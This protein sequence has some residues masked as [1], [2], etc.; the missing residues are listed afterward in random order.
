MLIGLKGNTLNETYEF[1][2]KHNIKVVHLNIQLTQDKKIALYENDASTK[3][4]KH[5]LRENILTLDEYLRHIPLDL[6]LILEITRKYGG[7]QNILPNDVV[8]KIIMATKKR[9]KKNIIYASEDKEII[10]IIIKNRREGML[11]ANTNQYE[12]TNLFN[13]PKEYLTSI[14][15]IKSDQQIYIQKISSQEELN[16]IISKYPFIK[17]GF[18]H[19]PTSAL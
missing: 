13:I 3:R 7:K 10:R 1:Y 6:M 14:N 11:I 19:L 9:G 5:L 17:G 18:L 12:D 2:Y 4:M 8:C 15:Q 16:E